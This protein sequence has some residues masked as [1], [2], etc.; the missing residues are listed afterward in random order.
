[1]IAWLLT[2]LGI[3]ADT[4]VVIAHLAVILALVQLV[5]DELGPK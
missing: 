1:M 3:V 4:L 2:V 5:M